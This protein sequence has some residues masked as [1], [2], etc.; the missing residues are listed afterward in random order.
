M[1]KI[2]WMVL[3]CMSF[4]ADLRAD[5]SSYLH[6]FDVN[7]DM[8][9]SDLDVYLAKIKKASQVYD[10]G[11][12]SRFDMGKKFKK[13]FSRTIKHYGMS[14]SRI[15]S[16]YEDDLLEMIN[17][18]P[19]ETYPYIGPMLH[20]IPGMSE[21]ILNLPGIKETKNKFPEEINEKYMAIEDIEFLSPALYVVLM[22]NFWEKGAADQD[23]PKE[24]PAQKPKK[25]MKLPNY[26]CPKSD[27]L[28]PQSEDIKANT[29]KKTTG[30]SLQPVGR[31]LYPTLV[32][33]L[34]TKDAE[35]FINTIDDIVEW[36]NKNGKKNLLAVLKA[37]FLLDNMEQEQGTSLQQN[38]LKDIVN[39]CQ[40]LVLK[41]RIAGIYH[42]FGTII[43]SKGFSPEE[44]AYTCDKTIKAFRVAQANHAEAYSVQYHRRGYYDKY[45]KMLPEKWQEAMFE[46]EA[47]I[48]AMYA[49]LYEDVASVRAIKSDIRKKF[50]QIDG[51]LL[52]EPIIY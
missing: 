12:V 6:A 13:E 32:S 43:A 7:M 45:I 28:A 22:P 23:K 2:I 37:G 25:H 5:A 39:P 36:G 19:K 16:R 49:V 30:T 24:V 17:M 33:P 29:I 50:N 15:K 10:K 3:I 44:W 40:R 47:A 27:P 18:L 9:L 8:D 48:I 11:Y 1:R 21:K 41:T 4:I 34:T 20:E 51:K 14:E 26:L 46:T 38:G 52:L 31:T 42:E 35:A